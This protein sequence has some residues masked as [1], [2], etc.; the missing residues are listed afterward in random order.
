MCD[1]TNSALGAVL[2]QRVRVGKP[3]HV[4]ADASQTMEPTQ[5]NYTI[6]SDHATLKYQLKKLDA[7][8]RLIEWIL[9]LQE[10]N[11]KIRD[12]KGAKNIG[13]PWFVNICNFLVTSTFPL[14]ASR[15]YKEKL[16]R[17][18]KYYVWDDPYLRRFC[19]DQI[20][21]RCILDAEF[22]S[23]LH[24]RHSAPG[25]DHYGSTQTAQK[26]KATATTTN[27]AKVVM[28]FLKFCVPKALISDQGTH[29]CNRVISSL[30]EKYG[31]IHIIVTQYHPQTNGQAE[32]FNREIKE[33]LQKMVNPNQK[34]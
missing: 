20:T 25:G 19:N 17:K 9:L 33:T 29:F 6:F 22:L 18:T 14:S 7:K 11:L 26:A 10:F 27:D 4:I 28:D 34:D 2:S 30:L 3:A 12:K 21:R 16:E 8:S 1:A 32:V 15:A 23:V 31:V 24:F 13:Q 5:I